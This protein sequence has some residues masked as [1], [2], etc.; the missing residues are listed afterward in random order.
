MLFITVPVARPQDLAKEGKGKIYLNDRIMEPLRIK[1]IGTEFT[2][3]LEVGSQITLPNNVGSS[4]VVEIISDTELIIKKEFKDL[5]ALA[6]LAKPE[7]S[8]YKCLPHV[9]Q[10]QV[11][12]A[13]FNTLNTGNCIGIFPEGGSHDRTEILPLKGMILKF[14][15]SW[16]NINYNFLNIT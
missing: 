3:Q 8:S 2:K 10:S 4:K 5:K 6:M 11:Y 13:V 9:D 12:K 15:S 7:G 16:F 1:G 14:L